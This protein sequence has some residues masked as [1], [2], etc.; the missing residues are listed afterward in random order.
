VKR[1]RGKGGTRED[2]K[3]NQLLQMNS[4]VVPQKEKKNRGRRRK[5]STSDKA[6]TKRHKNRP[7]L[8]A[9]TH[10]HTHICHKLGRTV[11]RAADAAKVQQPLNWGTKGEPKGSKAWQRGGTK[12]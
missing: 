3:K 9:H 12:G 11:A 4:S 7:M 2:N 1:E 8:Q 6:A 10:T 5:M